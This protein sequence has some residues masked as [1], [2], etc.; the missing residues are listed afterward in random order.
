MTERF[1]ANTR[2]S[3]WHK[4]GITLRHFATS[5]IFHYVKIISLVFSIGWF[6]KY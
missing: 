4:A 3:R 6:Q 1:L 5:E 2:S